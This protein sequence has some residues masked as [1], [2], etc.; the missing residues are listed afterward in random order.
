MPVFL[1]TCPALQASKTA[2]SAIFVGF[3][4]AYALLPLVLLYHTL[5]RQPSPPNEAT[6]AGSSGNSRPGI[7]GDNG[8]STLRVELTRQTTGSVSSASM[9]LTAVRWSSNSLSQLSAPI[10]VPHSAFAR[11]ATVSRVTN[12]ASSS[13]ASLSRAASTA[14]SDSGT[15]IF[16]SAATYTGHQDSADDSESQSQAG[17]SKGGG[18]L[19]APSAFAASAASGLGSSGASC[20]SGAAVRGRLTSPFAAV[21]MSRMST[22]VAQEPC[23]LAQSQEALVAKATCSAALSAP[24][25]ALQK[26]TAAGSAQQ[27]AAM[28]PGPD[29]VVRIDDGVRSCSSGGIIPCNDSSRDPSARSHVRTILASRSSSSSYAAAGNSN[30]LRMDSPEACSPGD[31]LSRAPSRM[32]LLQDAP[33]SA[34]GVMQRTWHS[35]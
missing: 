17:T 28:S 34:A 6:A 20:S 16:I 14:L 25:S 2:S 22:G 24:S 5:L 21:C 33:E 7:S 8:S 9:G 10:P 23:S 12:R 15:G 19:P 27:A 35:M 4:V 26:Q 11:H 18:S 3:L 1:T 32:G 29:A 30:S 13:F 31:G